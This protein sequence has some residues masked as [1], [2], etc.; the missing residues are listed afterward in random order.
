MKYLLD[1]GILLRVVNRDDPLHADVRRAL[2]RLKDGGHVLVTTPQNMSEF[3]NVSLAKMKQIA[4][5]LGARVIG[6][7]GEEY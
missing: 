2:R 3:W 5:R 1:T 4:V 7:G 6:D